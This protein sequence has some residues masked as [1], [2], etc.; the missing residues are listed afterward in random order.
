MDKTI[1]SLIADLIL[2]LSVSGKLL[3]LAANMVVQRL[4][5]C[6]Y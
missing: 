3:K 4:S 6:F 5:S 1:Q 2:F